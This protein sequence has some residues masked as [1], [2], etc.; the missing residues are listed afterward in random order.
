MRKIDARGIAGRLVG[1]EDECIA[2]VDAGFL[3][4]E[5]PDADFRALQVGKNADGPLELCFDAADVEDQAAQ[6]VML[7]VAHVDAEDVD[8]GA[9]ELLEHLGR[10]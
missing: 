9:K 4:G 3:F 6:Q 7:R 2:R 5:G 10:R 1:V 8:T